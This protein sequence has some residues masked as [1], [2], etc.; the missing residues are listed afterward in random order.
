MSNIFTIIFFRPKI[1]KITKKTVN[2]SNK[3]IKI[4]K[5][6]KIDSQREVESSK[7][8]I[9]ENK[10]IKEPAK[11]I[12]IKKKNHKKLSLHSYRKKESVISTF[13]NISTAITRITNFRKYSEEGRRRSKGRTRGG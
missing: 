2:K 7:E 11:C 12:K 9:E 8:K 13:L 10:D 1:G 3:G 4:K 6:T 5:E